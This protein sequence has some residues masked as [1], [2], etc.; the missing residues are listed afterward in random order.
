MKILSSPL[1]RKITMSIRFVFFKKMP[2]AK[3][4]KLLP[5]IRPMSGKLREFNEEDKERIAKIYGNES[6]NYI[7][8]M[9]CDDD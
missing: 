4:Q 7:L 6:R 2:I 5:I 3:P 8:E 9:A 1:A